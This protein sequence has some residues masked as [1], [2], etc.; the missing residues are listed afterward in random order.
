[1]AGNALRI[2][3]LLIFTAFLAAPIVGILAFGPA[4]P[5]EQRAQTALPALKAIVAPDGEGRDQLADFIFERSDL[6]R[7]AI[8]AK[9][10][11]NYALMGFADSTEVA[12]GAP[13][14]LFYKP[15]LASWSCEHLDENRARLER[16][17]FMAEMAAAAD[18]RFLLVVAPNKATIEREQLTGRAAQLAV[19]YFQTAD[20][21][22]QRLSAKGLTSV[23][24]HAP[25]V[26]SSGAPGERY[27]MTDTHWRPETA[28]LAFGDT[29]A[30]IGRPGLPDGFTPRS[31]PRA[32]STD[33]RTLLALPGEEQLTEIDTDDP[34]LRGFLA[35]QSASAR[36]TVLLHDSF[37]GIINEIVR[38]ALPDAR[39][40]HVIEDGEAARTALPEADRVIAEIVERSLLEQTEPTGAFHPLGPITKW[41]LDRSSAAA[42]Q[43]LW[44][45]AVDLLPAASRSNMDLAPDGAG[46]ATTNDPQIAASTSALSGQ[47]CLEIEIETQLP[48]NLQVFVG[49]ASGAFAE[50]RS[51]QRQ[52][53]P[54]LPVRMR[55]VLPASAIGKQLRIDPVSDEID[56]RLTAIRLAPAPP[57]FAPLQPGEGA[58]NA[59]KPS[60]GPA[61]AQVVAPGMLDAFII[62]EGRGDRGA[63]LSDGSAY[64]ARSKQTVRGEVGDG[65]GVL[66]RMDPTA[67][68]KFSGRNVE[69]EIVARASPRRGSPK[70]RVMY[71]RAGS[72]TTS[73]WRELD[74]SPDF[75]AHT[76][77]YQVPVQPP[78]PFDMI[79][80]WADPTGQDLGVDIQSVKVRTID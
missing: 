26:R 49:D 64:E 58:P 31:L 24:L 11:F 17:A 21:V 32:G 80:F 67:S 16:I 27:Y 29:L 45:Q 72:P 30:R 42:D 52:V 43:C 40:L 41:V 19:C 2:L 59:P 4:A 50:A 6:R 9:T 55:A 54:G 44:D 47:A 7:I 8:G 63:A 46:K 62:V 69:V 14:W 56:F 25:R 76:F 48:T 61:E 74:L 65:D 22:E 60:S 35:A 73:G 1:M 36:D 77:T 70:L 71:S 28:I 34:A 79:A 3:Q 66:V 18:L 75:E 57:R 10:S 12:S 33:L 13:G 23:L 68:R 20:M 5:Y 39:F 15:A 53:E 38:A 78:Q 37:Y 51:F